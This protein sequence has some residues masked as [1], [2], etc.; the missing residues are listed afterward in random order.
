MEE[1]EISGVLVE[2]ISAQARQRRSWDLK[3][4]DAQFFGGILAQSPQKWF[5]PLD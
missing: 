1:K 3:S 4:L 5:L 2:E